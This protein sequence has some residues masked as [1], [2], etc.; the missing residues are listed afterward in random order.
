[1]RNDCARHL[2]REEFRHVDELLFATHRALEEWL[3]AHRR[4]TQRRLGDAIRVLRT[5]H[6]PNQRHIRQCAIIVALQSAG[7]KPPRWTQSTRRARELTDHDVDEVLGYTSANHGAFL[8]A[9]RLTGATRSFVRITGLRLACPLA[10]RKPT[11]LS[12]SVPRRPVQ[13]ADEDVDPTTKSGLR[14]RSRAGPTVAAQT[15]I[16]A[17]QRRRRAWPLQ[18]RGSRGQF[19]AKSGQR[20]GDERA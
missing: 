8:L 10:T 12:L 9:K 16:A 7:Y 3:R 1:L 4:P 6:D 14:R 5:A 15:P 13:F 19:D 17:A 20:L 2:S 11:R 18:R